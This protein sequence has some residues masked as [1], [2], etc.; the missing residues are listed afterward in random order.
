MALLPYDASKFELLGG[1]FEEPMETAR[2]SS[3]DLMVPAWSEIVLE[4]KILSGVREPEGPFSEFTGYASSRS[5]E[6][7]FH[8]EAVSYRD[9]PMY[10]SICSGFA[11]DHNTIMGF[12]RETDVIE[13]VRRTVPNLQAVHVPNSGCGIFHCYI[14][15]KKTAEGQPQQAIY[16]ALGIDHGCKLVVVVDDLNVLLV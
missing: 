12:T 5:T 10:Q 7:V 6:H 13:A 2:C 14:S 1:L 15:I 9:E 8:V 3:I 4:G 16:A 11:G